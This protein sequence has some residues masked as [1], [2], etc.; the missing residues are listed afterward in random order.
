[1]N[2]GP[3]S[4]LITFGSGGQLL[5]WFLDRPAGDLGPVGF[6]ARCRSSAYRHRHTYAGTY[7]F[8]GH[9]RVVTFQSLTELICLVEWD[10]SGEVMTSP[11]SRSASCFAAQ[12]F[13]ILTSPRGSTTANHNH[14]HD[15]GVRARGLVEGEDLSDPA[16]ANRRGSPVEVNDIPGP[17]SM[18][19]CVIRPP[20]RR[21][22]RAERTWGR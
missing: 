20:P 1:M 5:W 2:D 6:G 3:D 11:R 7:L 9:R 13:I 10:H 16:M 14:C 15:G 8:G 17:G 22:Q 4:S 19:A 12:D 21:T 18:S